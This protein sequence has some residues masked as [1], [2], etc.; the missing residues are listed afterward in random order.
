MA[1]VHA[2][3]AEV[4]SAAG[5]SSLARVQAKKAESLYK[6]TL[7]AGHPYTIA[8]AA[9]ASR[10]AETPIAIATIAY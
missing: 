8:A 7:G 3:C 2:G 5:K 9:L 1:H 6:Q 10:C 4:L